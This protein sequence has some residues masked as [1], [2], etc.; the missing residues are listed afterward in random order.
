[1]DLLSKIKIKRRVKI[2]NFVSNS[3]LLLFYIYDVINII[4]HVIS[5][6]I[7]SK[8]VYTSFSFYS[9]CSFDLAYVN[10]F[11]HYYPKPK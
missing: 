10:Y 4:I 3:V 5:F 9:S 7:Y 11:I 6:T 1:M 2:T 8:F